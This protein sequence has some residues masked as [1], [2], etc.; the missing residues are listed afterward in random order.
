MKTERRKKTMIKNKFPH[1][2]LNCTAEKCSQNHKNEKITAPAAGAVTA[3]KKKVCSTWNE[4]RER[5]RQ[6]LTNSLFTNLNKIYEQPIYLLS[7]FSFF[8][9]F[10]YSAIIRD[11]FFFFFILC[12]FSF[13]IISLRIV[14]TPYEAPHSISRYANARA[15]LIANVFICLSYH[16]LI[17]VIILIIMFTLHMRVLGGLFECIYICVSVC[18]LANAGEIYT[19]HFVKAKQN[20]KKALWFWDSHVYCVQNANV[21]IV[22]QHIQSIYLWM[23]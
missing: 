6:H 23:I 11:S 14:H 20:K 15:L 1:T 21:K 19:F 16:I 22:N 10:F 9:L 12:S 17:I 13:A 8:Y 5:G 3:Y 7:N 18:A 2:S 4:K